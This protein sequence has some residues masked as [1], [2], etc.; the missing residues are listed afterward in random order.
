[1]D[2]FNQIQELL[3]MLLDTAVIGGGMA[4]GVLGGY[5]LYKLITIGSL[6]FLAKY[7][8]EKVYLLVRIRLE[9]KEAEIV[10]VNKV[11]IGGL[12]ITHDSTPV[13][14]V[15]LIEEIRTLAVVE[16]PYV[17]S[18]DIRKAIEIIKDYKKTL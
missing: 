1:M 9:K 4:I 7:T 6:I 13:L 12:F 16:S 3:Q 18:P 10:N 8:I 2:I 15:S 14:F 17:H 11:E 5:A